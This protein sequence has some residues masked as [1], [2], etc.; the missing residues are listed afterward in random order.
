[1]PRNEL[2][3]KDNAQERGIVPCG[4]KQ[5]G[6]EKIVPAPEN[7]PIHLCCIGS[8]RSQTYHPKNNITKNTNMVVLQIPIKFLNSKK[9]K[10][11]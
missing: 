6:S 8:M 5:G 1:M 3:A 10:L 4:N 11:T 7:N 9:L 2:V